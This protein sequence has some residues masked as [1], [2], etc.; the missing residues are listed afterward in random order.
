MFR[1]TTLFALV[2][3]ALVGVS[4]VPSAKAS[5]TSEFPTTAQ[6]QVMNDT[7]LAVVVSGGVGASDTMQPHT[8]DNLWV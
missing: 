5:D 3:S 4:M 6:V 2:V 7:N 8:C 1:F